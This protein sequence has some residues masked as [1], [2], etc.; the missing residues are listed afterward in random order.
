[1]NEI[2][3]IF[4]YWNS[5]DGKWWKHK[6]IKPFM[7]T[8]IRDAL[9]ILGSKEEVL[10]AIDNYHEVLT[11]PKYQ[12]S[13]KWPIHLFMKQHRPGHKTGDHS[14]QIVRFSSDGF[15]IRDFPLLNGCMDEYEC[16][17]DDAKELLGL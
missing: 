9:R 15:C 4:D 3:D 16:T 5:R 14:L 10:I 13:M 11:N 2:Q 1:M 12:W 17:E 6:A 7:A 8:A